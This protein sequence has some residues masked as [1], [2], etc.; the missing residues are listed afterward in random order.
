M[1]KTLLLVLFELTIQ[2]TFS[3]QNDSRNERPE[4]VP[5]KIIIK[6]KKEVK[7]AKSYSLKTYSKSTAK[8]IIP[9][10]VEKILKENEVITL[11]SLFEDEIFSRKKSKEKSAIIDNNNFYILDFDKAKDPKALSE[12]LNKDANIAYAEPD[13]YFRAMVETPNDQKVGEQWYLET[14]QAFELRHKLTEQ[15]NLFIQV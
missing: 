4:Y 9:S 1:K 14:I 7:L 11:K 2:F 3:Q 13:Y 12:E 6:F 10:S 8:V 15:F 5:G